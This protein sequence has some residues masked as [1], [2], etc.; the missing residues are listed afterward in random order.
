MPSQP[1]GPGGD[2]DREELLRQF[3]AAI[4]GLDR[5]RP[6]R[7]R[8]RRAEPATYRVRVDLQGTQPP[9]WRRL[10]LSSELFLDDLH[11]ILQA[12]FGWTDSHLHRYAVGA[13]VWDLGAE[14]YL[15]PFDVEE[16]DSEGVP[17]QDVRL[18]EVLVEP[19]D[20][21]RYVYDYG[22]DWEHVVR[23]EEVLPHDPESPRAVCT[24]GRRAGPPEDCGG[25][26]GFEELVAAGELDTDAF[27]VAEVNESVTAALGITD[28]PSAP[29][30]AIL[31]RLKAH[32]VASRLVALV[33]VAALDEPADIDLPEAE[34]MVRRYAW[35]LDRT[36]DDGI[37]LT[38]AGYLPPVHVEAAMTELGLADDW[39]GKGNREDLTW[40]VLALRESATKLGLLRKHRGRLLATKQGRR[41]RDDP[42]GLWWHIVQRMPLGEP[43]S[44]EH[45]AG[46]VTLLGVAAG[47]DPRDA[48]LGSV[49]AEVLDGL[50]WLHW[51]GTRLSGRA[52][53]AV[54][55]DVVDVLEHCRAFGDHVGVFDHAEPVPGGRALARAVLQRR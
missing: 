18:D 53:A 10:E 54:A 7:R 48:E 22:D 52:A 50:G 49:L 23:L 51:D 15:C 1:T 36:G 21:L 26:P 45:Q 43:R 55:R 25:I 37:K 12:A 34:R 28:V 8:P 46:V 9:V 44:A 39:I 2:E 14:L 30:S 31:K 42:V 41:L 17:E 20:T 38:A 40:P 47:S 24:G 4:A 19:G 29:L 33:A 6:N 3:D 11:E 16:G 13:S 32:P 5:P 35:M 27:D